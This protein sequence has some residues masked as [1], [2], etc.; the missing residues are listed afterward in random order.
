MSLKSI[1]PR[2]G[3]NFVWAMQ[4]IQT[5]STFITEFVQTLNDQYILYRAGSQ[6]HV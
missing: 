3:C 1:L 6:I 4:D 2:T 5:E